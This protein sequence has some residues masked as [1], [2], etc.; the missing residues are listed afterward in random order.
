[1]TEYFTALSVIAYI[2]FSILFIWVIYIYLECK[3]EIKIYKKSLTHYE[4]IEKNWLKVALNKNMYFHQSL[5]II[6]TTQKIPWLNIVDSM[7]SDHSRIYSHTT[8]LSTLR[9]HLNQSYRPLSKSIQLLKSIAPVAGML[10]T[11][12]GLINSLI[13]QSLNSNQ[14]QLFGDM[15]VA[16]TTTACSSTILLIL[17][18]ISSSIDNLKN[19]NYITGQK[20]MFMLLGNM[21]K[22]EENK[23]QQRGQSHEL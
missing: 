13:N 10:F 19:Q 1:M 17:Y 12:L 20:L 22:L 7:K 15:S 4:S 16:F 14:K 9:D 6:N 21:T 11:V 2:F 23:N 18:F 3:D 5:Q 8:L